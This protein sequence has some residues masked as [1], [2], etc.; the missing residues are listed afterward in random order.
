M[1]WHG[2]CLYMYINIELITVGLREP[3][4]S[5]FKIVYKDK[6]VMVVAG[7]GD[8]GKLGRHSYTTYPGTVHFDRPTV[9]LGD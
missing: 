9:K 5:C 7:T 4:L 8:S 6:V 3:F 1:R 2:L